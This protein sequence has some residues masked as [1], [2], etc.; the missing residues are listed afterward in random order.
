MAGKKAEPIEVNDLAQMRALV[1]PAR[2]TVLQALYDGDPLTATQAAELTG[3][4]PSAMSYHLKQ[5]AK[6]GLIERAPKT[7]DGRERPWVARGGGLRM[8]AQPDEFVGGIMM[9]HLMTALTK[10]VAA[11]PPKDPEER[12]WPAGYSQMRM[13]IS[14]ERRKEMLERLQAILDEYDEVEDPDAPEIDVF[15]IHGPRVEP[16]EGRDAAAPASPGDGKA[17]ARRSA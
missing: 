12:P 7:D 13:R 8:S 4:T 17:S 14:K 5:L 11:P 10:V 9:R 6:M 3:L 16:G 2:W 1:H 15:L